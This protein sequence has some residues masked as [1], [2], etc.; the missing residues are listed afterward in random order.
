MLSDFIQKM[1]ETEGFSNEKTLWQ[2]YI[3]GALGKQGSGAGIILIGHERIKIKYAIR[4]A[5]CAIN[6]TV[7]YEALITGLKLVNEVRTESLQILC[8]S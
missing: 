7:E 1:T 6:N 3:D 5:Y 2:M 8:D 4:I